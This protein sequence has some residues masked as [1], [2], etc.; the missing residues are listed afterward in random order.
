MLR[1]RL[2]GL[3][4]D[5]DSSL[6]V[7][8]AEADRASDVPWRL[9]RTVTVSLRDPGKPVLSRSHVTVAPVFDVPVACGAL[10]LSALWHQN[11]KL[12]GAFL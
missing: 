11:L 12:R 6:G 2:A 9:G 4:P 1:V 8:G 7:L 3:G 5:S 10:G